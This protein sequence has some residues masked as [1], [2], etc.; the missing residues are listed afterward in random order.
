MADE[1]TT[2]ETEVEETTTTETEVTE[3]PAKTADQYRQEL[4]QYERTSKRAMATKDK[5]LEEL[6]TKLAER[7][8][9]DKTEQER[10][11]EQARQEAQTTAKAEV[12][13][14]FQK[15]I[16]NAE[17]R[18]LAAG[19]FA[20]PTLAVKLLDLDDTVF[21]EDG[22]VD[23]DAVTAAIDEFLEQDENAGLRVN[24]NG[25]R[26]HGDADGGRGAGGSKDLDA[27]SVEEHMKRQGRA[28]K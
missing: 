14:A 18:A 19:K 6:R 21:N 4:R 22:D 2:T 23:T 25:R 12:T 3:K 5:E 13:S 10:A 26:D 27:M 16:L 9:Q 24:G 7:E 20:N 1:E 17:I 28:T 11:L 8:D 15:R